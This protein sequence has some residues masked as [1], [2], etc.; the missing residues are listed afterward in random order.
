MVAVFIDEQE[1]VTSFNVLQNQGMVT[2]VLM[3]VE[4]KF[5]KM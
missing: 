2:Y 1:Y 4:F 3:R 5:G